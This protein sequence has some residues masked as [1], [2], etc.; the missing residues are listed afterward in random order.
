[1]PLAE[2]RLHQ[3]VKAERRA[4]AARRSIAFPSPRPPLGGF[5]KE[6]SHK[7]TPLSRTGS[8]GLCRFFGASPVAS[9]LGIRRAR[10][11]T[12]DINLTMPLRLTPAL[13]DIS[14][15]PGLGRF[16]FDLTL[17]S[18]ASACRRRR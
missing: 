18:R 4:N 1:M 15:L 9:A 17:A 5:T 13:Q 11:R 8:E 16:Y 12:D 6:Y 14:T 3:Y 2:V 10:P 7:K